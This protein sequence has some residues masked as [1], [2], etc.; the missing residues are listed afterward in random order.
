MCHPG[1]HPSGASPGPQAP[2]LT[3][4]SVRSPAHGWWPGWFPGQHLTAGRARYDQHWGL[5]EL[6]KGDGGS[7]VG[8]QE[9]SMEPMSVGAHHAHH[10]GRVQVQ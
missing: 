3:T 8:G 9:L 2:S 6:C 7:M 5:S 10:V 4:S 1:S